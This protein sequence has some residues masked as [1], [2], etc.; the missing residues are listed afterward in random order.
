MA[1]GSVVLWLVGTALALHAIYFARRQVAET[2]ALRLIIAGGVVLPVV[3]LAAL[4]VHGLSLLPPLL[5][6]AAGG[7]AAK[8]VVTGEQWWWRVRY[9]APD[10][11]TF[12]LANEL[13]LP[14]GQQV[15]VLL[16]SHYV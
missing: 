13:R 7:G 5:A 11:T 6:S 15:D 8:I 4:L 14:V 10:G 2:T 16:E 3:L 9:V 1:G 12:D